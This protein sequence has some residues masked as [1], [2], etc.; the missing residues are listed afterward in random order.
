MIRPANPSF[1]WRVR[2]VRRYIRMENKKENMEA[3]RAYKFRIYPDQKRQMDR[4]INA[5]I[6]IL[7][8]ALNSAS[9]NFHSK[10]VKATLG[11]RGSH[12]QGDMTSAVQQASKSRI[13]EL[14]TYSANAGE[15]N[16]L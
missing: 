8:R 6:N 14:R 16:N 12:A 11:Q 15:T 3:M 10:A 1:Q 7:N 2:G 4:D 5:S 9:P 13:E